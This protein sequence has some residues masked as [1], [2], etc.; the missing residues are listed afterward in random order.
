MKLHQGKGHYTSLAEINITPFVDVVL[1]LLIIFMITAPLLREGLAID[2]PK[3]E[4]G[5]MT[6]NEKD[7]IL[8]ID[9]GNRI[10]IGKT[11]KPIS[12]QELNAKLHA[13]YRNKSEKNLLI[14]GDRSLR[15]DQVIDVM[16]IAK[17][18]GVERI[19]LITESA[20]K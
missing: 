6:Q 15:Y 17:K 11:K 20:P 5:K 4:A 14:Q 2:V 1:V 12:L 13:I 3:A 16:V 7:V 9:K 19:G 8:S 10:Y 18:A